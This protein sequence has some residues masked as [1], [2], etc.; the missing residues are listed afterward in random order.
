MWNGSKKK[1]Q[2]IYLIEVAVKICLK[3]QSKYVKQTNKCTIRFKETQSSFKKNLNS[4]F[5]KIDIQM[6]SG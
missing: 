6:A 1:L 5:S 3:K 4:Y 2:F